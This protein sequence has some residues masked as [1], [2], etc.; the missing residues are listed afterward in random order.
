MYPALTVRGALGSRVSAVMWYGRAGGMEATLTARAGI[1]FRAVRTGALV[2][3]GPRGVLAGAVA[4]ARGTLA[5]ARDLRR[6]RP[7][8]VFVT[9][10]YVSVP[11]AV[12]A[13]LTGTPLCVYLPDIFPGR[14]VQLIARLADRICVTAGAA[15]DALPRRARD[16]A[17]VTGYPVRPLVRDADRA[18]ARARLAVAP[19]D[20]VVL[21]FGGSQGARRINDAVAD[22]A[23]ALLARAVVLHAAGATTLPEATAARAAL[24]ERLGA[25]LAARWRLAPY[26]EDDAMA[27][28]LAAADVVVC[29]AGAA[30]LGELPARGLP[31]ILVPLPISGGH[32]WPNARVLA[33]AGA[34]VVVADADMD[35]AR[36]A[37]EVTALLDD[38]SRRAAMQ[39][40]ARRLDRPAAAE[41]IAQVILA[42]TSGR[43]A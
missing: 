21:V 24:A 26:F 33:D 11:L 41:S 12:A 37:T 42:M 32:Q 22:A 4:I 17:T 36:L 35:G 15:L 27:D 31:A 19:D 20:A 9:G 38:P 25:D 10:G 7:D 29:R 14:A 40:A 23:P 34:A 18:A 13:R 8:A 39:A 28:G 16:R 1:P 6:E 5:A 2:D 3:R 30:V 43:A